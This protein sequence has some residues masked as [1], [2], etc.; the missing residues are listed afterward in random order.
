VEIF[1]R[2]RE[3]KG[4]L[5][6][7]IITQKGRGYGPAEKDPQKFHG[8]SVFDKE[9]GEVLPGSTPP[10]PTY[11]GVFGESLVALGERF[12]NLY[13][14]TAAM[15]DGTGLKRFAERFPDRF[16]DVGIAESHAVC[17]AAGLACEGLKPV[18]AI[19]STF[20][21]RAYDQVIHDVCLQNL[22]V[23]LVMDRGGLVGEDGET[24]QGAFDLSFLR[25]VP[26]LVVMAPANA[27]EMR[28]MLLTAVE[29]DGPVAL[30]Y[31]RSP[32]EGVP[33]GGEFHALPLGKGIVT[34]EGGDYALAAV[35]RMVP[36]AEK[37][38]ETLRAEGLAGTVINMRF[39]RPLDR[40]LLLSVSRRVP[41][42]WTLEEN[43]VVGGFGTACLEALQEAGLADRVRGMIGIPDRFIEHGKPSILREECGLEPDQVAQAV[44]QALRGGSR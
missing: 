13:A 8:I 42:L 16:I 39:V 17:M 23:V 2:V 41:A 32:V 6:L 14:I 9:T 5:L 43:S 31:P 12:P 26:N 4:P 11:T 1:R 44:R 21:Q 34:R 38:W 15:A 10:A 18:V 24:H 20:M 36:G 22:P 25:C 30:R 27:D 33:L 7:H 29:H 35:G 40:E 28:H 37:A 19:Y 3:L